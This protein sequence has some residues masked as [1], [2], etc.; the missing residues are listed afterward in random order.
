MSLILAHKLGFDVKDEMLQRGIS[1]SDQDIVGIRFYKDFVERTMLSRGTKELLKIYTKDDLVI[2][3]NRVKQFTRKPV[4]YVDHVIEN[5][6]FDKCYE[7]DLY[8]RKGVEEYRYERRETIIE[9][10]HKGEISLI[11]AHKMCFDVRDEML[12]R[13]ISIPDQDLLDIRFYKNYLEVTILDRGI[14]E[15]LKI[16]TPDEVADYWE[17]VRVKADEKF[18]ENIEVP[19]DNNGSSENKVAQDNGSDVE[20]EDTDESDDEN[21]EDDDDEYSYVYTLEEV[22]ALNNAEEKYEVFYMSVKPTK[23]DAVEDLFENLGLTLEDAVDMFFD[24]SLLAG[25]LPFEQN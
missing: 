6:Q 25:G 11:L 15:L 17:L 9:G 14:K 5:V 16:F 13:G 2:F 10:V 19:A 22:E 20:S 7:N 18:L 21:D 4:G 12:Q 8:F 3:F 1:I 24:K 23:R